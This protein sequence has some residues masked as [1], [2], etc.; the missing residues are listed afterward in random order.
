MHVCALTTWMQDAVLVALI[1]EQEWQHSGLDSTHGWKIEP[2]D[3]TWSFA[4]FC[5]SAVCTRSG[6]GVKQTQLPRQK[7]T[8]QEVWRWQWV[9]TLAGA[10]IRGWRKTGI[11]GKWNTTC[12]TMLTRV[13]WLE[14]DTAFSVWSVMRDKERHGRR[15]IN[16]FFNTSFV[17]LC[18]WASAGATTVAH[19]SILQG[20]SW[21]LRQPRTYGVVRNLWQFYEE[22]KVSRQKRSLFHRSELRPPSIQDYFTYILKNTIHCNYTTSRFCITSHDLWFNVKKKTT[23]LQYNNASV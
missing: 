15:A 18:A 6:M 7:V 19:A 13:R 9:K 17:S 1:A 12:F 22:N 11:S 8:H 20:S 16:R 10:R 23:P 3:K 4:A 2:G 5:A 14:V 21:N